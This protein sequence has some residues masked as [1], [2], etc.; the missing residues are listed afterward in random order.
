L[1]TP[2]MKVFN[3]LGDDKVPDVREWTSGIFVRKNGETKV[4]LPAHAYDCVLMPQNDSL[5]SLPPLA[6]FQGNEKHR[7]EVARLDE[8]VRFND[9]RTDIGLASIKPEVHFENQTFHDDISIRKLI[10]LEECQIRDLFLIDSYITGPQKLFLDGIRYPV[11]QGARATQQYGIKTK[12]L[13]SDLLLSPRLPYLEMVQGMF[14]TAAL[15]IPR[16][17]Q[18]RAGVCGSALIRV[19]TVRGVDVS[20]EGAVA[21]FMHFAD[22]EP[23]NDAE[24]KLV[25]YA[26]ACNAL[27]DQGWSVA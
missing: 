25:C 9:V 14:S 10:R 21:G 4:T 24:G 2:G 23:R 12:G 5:T 26:D 20:A 3:S 22:L 7:S 16:Q 15:E 6:V 27:I 1:F 17:P 18:I 8:L 13:S 19:R 11:R